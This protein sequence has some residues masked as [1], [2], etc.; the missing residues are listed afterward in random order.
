MKT[1]AIDRELAQELT[2]LAEAQ[3][4]ATKAAEQLANEPNSPEARLAVVQAQAAI[5]EIEVG[6]NALKAARNAAEKYDASEEGQAQRA[7]RTETLGRVVSTQQALVNAAQAIDEALQS[8]HTRMQ[9]FGA[10]HGAAKAATVAYLDLNETDLDTRMHDHELLNRMPGTLAHAVMLNLYTAL[11]ASGLDYIYFMRF[12]LYE[13]TPTTGVGGD[14]KRE[15]KAAAQ[16]N[17]AQIAKALEHIE[18]INNGTYI[19]PSVVQLQ[20]APLQE[21]EH[22]I[23]KDFGDLMI[24]MGKPKSKQGE[25]AQAQTH[26]TAGDWPQFLEATAGL[27]SPEV[28]NQ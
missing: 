7:R 25:A 22:Y 10:A 24:H 16:A 17:A 18:A 9:Q 8:L 12:N 26:V 1:A 2:Q 4:E 3:A 13:V 14:F 28:L 19:P 20:A 5:A 27:P 6:I 11:E 23:A 15:M 21:G